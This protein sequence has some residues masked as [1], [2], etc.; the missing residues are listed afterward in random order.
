MLQF[1]LSHF[2]KEESIEDLWAQV[3]KIHEQG[4]EFANMRNSLPGAKGAFEPI[5]EPWFRKQYEQSE[6][7]MENG[8][9]NY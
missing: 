5:D 6:I 2:P 1:P 3:K 7:Q 9:I 8:I 4:Q